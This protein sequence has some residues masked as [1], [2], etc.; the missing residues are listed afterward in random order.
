MCLDAIVGCEV[1]D[2]LLEGLNITP[3]A[4]TYCVEVDDWVAYEL[5]WA[6][7]GD[8]A[9]AVDV[10]E[11]RAEALEI[12]LRAEHI[13]GMTTLSEGV[14]G[15]VLNDENGATRLAL[16]ERLV[17]LLCAQRIEERTLQIPALAIRHGL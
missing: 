7:E 13:L 9:A 4:Q 16:M 14:D 12:L 15:G 8:V 2:S 6:M 3:Y 1:D 5:S 17:E 11:L 10:I